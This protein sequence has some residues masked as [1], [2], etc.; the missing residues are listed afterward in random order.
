MSKAT[1]LCM[2]KNKVDVEISSFY[3]LLKRY[4]KIQTD[5]IL[6]IIRNKLT[7]RNFEN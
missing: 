2:S 4:F 6:P 1:Q 3:Q 5:K 7:K